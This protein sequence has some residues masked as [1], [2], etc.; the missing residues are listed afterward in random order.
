MIRHIR[1]VIAAFAFLGFGLTAPQATA[2]ITMAPLTTWGS[3]VSSP[4]PGW[5]PPSYTTP[6]NSTPYAYLGTSNNERGL[7]VNPVNGDVYLISHASVSGTSA[8]VRILNGTTGADVGGLSN[9]GIAGG[10]FVVNAAAVSADGG[11][12]VGNLTTNN[13]TTAYTVYKWATEA[14]T[15]TV[16]L[17]TT[18]LASGARVGDDLAAIGSGSSTQLAA[19]YGTGTAG[20]VIVNPT[21]STAASVTPIAGTNTGD[22]KQGITFSDSSHVLGS[23]TSL[24]GTYRYTSFSGSSGTLVATGTLATAGSGQPS[25]AAE[26]LLGYS[27]APIG[28]M[29]LLAVQSTGDGHV[30]IYN[31]NDPTN[32][33]WLASG[34]NIVGTP[35]ANGNLTGQL[36]WNIL[37][38]NDAILYAMSTN[39]GIQAFT[40]TATPAP[41][42]TSLALVG[43]AGLGLAFRRFRRKA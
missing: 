39:S 38:A 32:P 14:S 18:A 23:Q 40:I 4:N 19:G 30:S 3:I 33:V 11:I 2:Q 22:F 8:N 7:A 41:E 5:L 31:D 9:T 34:D 37:D 15:P 28:G 42:P 17:S 10:T 12:Y 6:T 16:A 21:A 24:A 27:P 29:E 25:T 43:L 36:G 20:Y 13:T 35:V 26:V 1:Y